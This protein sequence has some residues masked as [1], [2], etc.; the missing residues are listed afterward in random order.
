[1][2][3][4]KTRGGSLYKIHFGVTTAIELDQ[5]K[6]SMFFPVLKS[7][8][9]EG[10]RGREQR[11]TK[12]SCKPNQCNFCCG[13][14]RYIGITKNFTNLPGLVHAKN[15]LATCIPVKVKH[16]QTKQLLWEL[17]AGQGNQKHH[18][19]LSQMIL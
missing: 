17:Q 6:L 8:E 15:L 16:H 3:K 19:S 2:E 9:K 5:D 18:K 11:C 12:C 13:I 1:M 10:H 7:K 14:S 4:H